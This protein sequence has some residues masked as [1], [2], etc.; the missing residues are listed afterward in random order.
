MAPIP[1]LSVQGHHGQD[2]DLRN[3]S[4]GG[5]HLSELYFVPPRV[6]KSLHEKLSLVARIF[7]YSEPLYP[8]P[9]VGGMR[10]RTSVL[11][12]EYFRLHY[13]ARRPHPRSP[14]SLGAGK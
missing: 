12:K 13:L 6:P 7:R 3:F 2:L 14:Q 4:H 10:I 11:P 5:V 9:D 1:K 8:P